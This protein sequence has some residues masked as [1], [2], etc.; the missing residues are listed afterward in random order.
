MIGPVFLVPSLAGVRPGDL[1]E[2]TGDEAHHA[3]AVRRTRTGEPVALTEGRGGVALGV[4]RATG[5]RVMQVQVETLTD[6]DEP[7]PA[8]WVV[9]A[10]PKGDR[11]ER[12]VEMLTE[13]GVARIIP[14]AAERSVGQWRGERGDKA[15]AKWRATAR[16]SSKQAR[17][18][19]LAEV[20]PLVTTAEL[21]ALIGATELTVVLHEQAA[22][23]LADVAIPEGGTIVLIVGP[24]GGLSDAEVKSLTEAGG[25]MIGLGSEVLR[26]STAGVAAAAAV[27]SR[28]SRWSGRVG[29]PRTS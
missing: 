7:S 1:V 14:W 13:I 27:L 11:G 29:P 15:L 18:A 6:H 3:V 8:I 19:W 25:Q 2:I 28:T 26:T 4:V 20:A 21:L 22:E 9:Q 12:A 23:S 5:R 16:E 17:R 24:E 10:L